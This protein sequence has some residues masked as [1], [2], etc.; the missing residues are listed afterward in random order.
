MP[1]LVCPAATGSDVWVNSDE[2]PV[3]GSKN[4]AGFGALRVSRSVSR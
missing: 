2:M 1:A 3:A 4:I